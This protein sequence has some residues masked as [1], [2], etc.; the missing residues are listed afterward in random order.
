MSRIAD[1]AASGSRGERFAL[2]AQRLF[3]GRRFVD[4]PVVSVEDGVVV[5]VGSDVG[6]AVVVEDL[7]A[8]TL[9]PGLVDCHQHLVFDGQGTLEEM[10]TGRSDDELRARAW[11]AARRALSGGVTTL[12]D[13][14]DRNYVTLG[15]RGDPELPTILCSGPPITPVGGHCWYLGGECNGRDALLDAVQDRVAQGCDVVK[16]MA[17]G[18]YLTPATP[19]WKSQFGLGDLQMVVDEAHG[20]GLTVAAHCHGLQGIDDAITAGVDTIEHCTFMN[21]SMQIAPDT[22]LLRRLA[23]SRIPISATIGTTPGAV[24][25]ELIEQ[26]LPQVMGHFARVRALGGD[27]VVGTDAGIEPYKPHDVAAHAIHDLLA[28]GMGGVEALRALTRGGAEALGQT[29]KGRI[30]PGADADL[31]AVHGDPSTE[32]AALARIEQV[33]R[34]GRP[35][36]RR[37]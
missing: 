24:L 8:I 19:M 2:R 26:L 11:A 29:S 31:V 5:G 18:G 7:G 28:M 10:V 27:V 30:E 35:V 16:I 33:W 23:E 15:L 21:E 36:H 4:E 13:L 1:A 3:D 9:L 37:P 12:R 14:G 20:S 32:P 25:P 17:T 22:L 6:T 34:A